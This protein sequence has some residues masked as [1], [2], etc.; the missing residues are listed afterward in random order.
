[1]IPYRG[2]HQANQKM[3]QGSAG[4]DYF[5]STYDI[6]TEQIAKPSFYCDTGDLA[7][8]ASSGHTCNLSQ[9]YFSD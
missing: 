1:M 2:I 3:F 6:A 5:T 9:H 4:N 8:I 7:C